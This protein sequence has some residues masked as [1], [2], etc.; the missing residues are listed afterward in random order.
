M[1]RWLPYGALAVFVLGVLLRVLGSGASGPRPAAR[2]ASSWSWSWR[3]GL[4][5]AVLGHLVGL[6]APGVLVALHQHPVT[7]LAVEGLA[8]VFGLTALFGLLLE[9]CSSGGGLR[10]KSLLDSLGLTFLG[11]ALVSGVSLTLL[12]RSAPA[13]YA[14]VLTPYLGSLLTLEPRVALISPLPFWARLHLLA[15]FLLLAVAPWTT[16]GALLASRLSGPRDPE[17]PRPTRETIHHAA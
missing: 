8:L 16:A 13:W 7:L 14:T 1:F 11:L 17:S 15:V 5:G 6:L 3:I 2:R 12:F 10:P 9:A 4:A